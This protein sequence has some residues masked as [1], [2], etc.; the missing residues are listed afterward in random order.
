M[1]LKNKIAW[2]L[3]ATTMFSP[4]FAMLPRASQVV[5]QQKTLFSPSRQRLVTQGALLQTQTRYMTQPI[6]TAPIAKALPA[7]APSTGFF[8]RMENSWKAFKNWFASKAPAPSPISSTALKSKL[9]ATQQLLSMPVP[10][11]L[12]E[13]P[14]T[15]S[16]SSTATSTIAQ[17]KTAQNLSEMENILKNNEI[18]E[19]NKQKGLLNISSEQWLA[20]LK[21]E[22]EDFIWIKNNCFKN[23]N[24]TT[25]DRSK[26]PQE[27]YN[28]IRQC[29]KT[30]NINPQ[31]VRLVWQKIS[32]PDAFG[33]KT[34]VTNGPIVNHNTTALENIPTITFDPDKVSV[35]SPEEL[36]TEMYHAVTHLTQGHHNKLKNLEDTVGNEKF[37]K[38]TQ[39]SDG[40]NYL[41]TL[42]DTAH[43]LM[44]IQNP[45]VA[46]IT[47][48]TY[49]SFAF[50]YFLNEMK[51]HLI[52]Y[53]KIE[54]NT[55]I[56]S[57]VNEEIVQFFSAIKSLSDIKNLCLQKRH[58]IILSLG[59][60]EDEINAYRSA[61]VPMLIQ[62]GNRYRLPSINT[63]LSQEIPPKLLE[64]VK[65]LLIES[66]I[67]PSSINIMSMPKIYAD[68]GAK[69]AVGVEP[70]TVTE[71]NNP[72][73][74]K[75]VTLFLSPM[76]DPNDAYDIT[77]I[78][79]E[80]GHLV[81]MH[82]QRTAIFMDMCRKKSEK[83]EGSYSANDKKI[84]EQ[85]A[86]AAL[87]QI[88]ALEELEAD[89]FSSAKSSDIAKLNLV[90][91][92]QKIKHLQGT[93]KSAELSKR[94]SPAHMSIIEQ[95]YVYNKIVQLHDQEKH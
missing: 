3:C 45:E 48:K 59:F 68:Q 18:K 20:L 32:T 50:N 2:L 44:P 35:L 28:T 71:R 10:K 57:P 7:P 41:N 70:V 15:L 88:Q 93:V 42:K 65:K 29:L 40:K 55:I 84:F 30:A 38:Y 47:K 16:V 1:N 94:P 78:L 4:C 82:G 24:I 21:K 26:I 91:F 33:H 83:L 87:A 92:Y 31:S 86:V 67:Q 11:E 61:L 73:F 77:T 90:V 8:A 25:D 49:L 27:I 60:K 75:S 81:N 19:H 14:V 52:Q 51:P 89:I 76:L 66:E 23:K 34:I 5:R 79:H 85:K 63:A 64:L 56:C 39:S 13:Q 12:M 74:I 95:F 17:L 46:K 80:I 54:P 22:Q 36:S 69:G 62:E 58:D 9:P 72:K 37:I 6:K 53:E 43:F